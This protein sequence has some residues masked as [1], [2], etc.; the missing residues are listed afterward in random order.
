MNYCFSIESKGNIYSIDM[1]Y[2]Q[3]FCRISPEGFIDKLNFLKDSFPDMR[4]EEYLERP[5]HSKYDFFRF[6]VVFGGS[7]IDL[8]KYCDYSKETKTFHLLPMI[9][10]RV[11][12]NKC[13]TLDWFQPLLNLIFEYCTSGYLRKFDF[14]VDIPCSPDNVFVFDSRKEKGLYKGT[15]YFGQSGRHNF[16]KIYDKKKE[17]FLDYELTRVEHTFFSNKDFNFENV[18]VR[19]SDCCSNVE[20]DKLTSTDRSIVDM[21]KILRRFGV[22][23]P[24]DLGRRKM[25]KLKNFL[26]GDFIPLDYGQ[27]IYPLLDFY[28]DLFKCDMNCPEI[29]DFFYE[30]YSDYV[31]FD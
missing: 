10:L 9:Q 18:Y 27:H 20:F 4:Y 5:Y 16:C 17:S 2:I 6:G 21:Y 24:L 1:V 11:N 22:E 8:G 31:P 14:A 15:R 7:F 28:M 30:N 3:Y 19:S 23:Y 29:S 26:Y 25:D 13:F 12:P